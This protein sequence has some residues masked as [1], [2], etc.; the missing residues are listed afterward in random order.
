[1]Q[2]P[3]YVVKYFRKDFCVLQTE[4]FGDRSYGMIEDAIRNGAQTLQEV[5]SATGAAK[6]CGQCG[7][8]LKC[9]I[10]DIKDEI[11]NQ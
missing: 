1:M 11:K 10:R 8:F 6:G 3:I 2:L 4:S 9:L 5:Q 7:D